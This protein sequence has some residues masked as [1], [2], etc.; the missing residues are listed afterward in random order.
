M[1]VEEWLLERLHS[2][3]VGWGLAIVGLTLIVRAAIVPI[4]VR[5]F[6]AQRRLAEHA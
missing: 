6:H 4:T 5:Q 2:V 1:N 3:G